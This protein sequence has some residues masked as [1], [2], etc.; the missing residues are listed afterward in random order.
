LH[1]SAPPFLDL[2]DARVTHTRDPRPR[3][4]VIDDSQEARDLYREL[5]GFHGFRIDCADGGAEGLARAIDTPPDVMILDF[6]MPGMDGGEVLRRLDADERTRTIPVVMVTAAAEL[7]SDEARNACAALLEKPC[8]L[9]GLLRTI[10]ALVDD[11]RGVRT[12]DPA[13]RAR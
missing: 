10:A 3:V 7:V 1:G 13:L 6:S 11:Q 12:S 8:E 2:L 5:L 9:D 4:L